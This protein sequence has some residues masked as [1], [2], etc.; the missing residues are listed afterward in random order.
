M[1]EVWFI[2]SLISFHSGLF[3]SETWGSFSQKML[4]AQKAAKILCTSPFYACEGLSGCEFTKFVE[5]K[6]S[7][8]PVWMHTSS[9]L[10]NPEVYWAKEVYWCLKARRYTD[11]SK[12]MWWTIWVL[13]PSSKNF[14]LDKVHLSCLSSW[15]ICQFKTTVKCIILL[16]LAFSN[17]P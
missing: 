15:M 4:W 3:T 11:V 2:F 8:K 16:Q 5:A 9:W 13:V 7:K 14:I 6:V 12:Q 1:L 10:S 17:P